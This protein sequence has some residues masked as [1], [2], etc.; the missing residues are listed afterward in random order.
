MAPETVQSATGHGITIATRFSPFARATAR[1][2]PG[3]PSRSASMLR[4]ST[5]TLSAI[6]RTSDSTSDVMIQFM[7]LVYPTSAQPSCTPVRLSAHCGRPSASKTAAP[8]PQLP[9]TNRPGFS[10]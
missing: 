10:E 4:R 9:S 5:P 6:V 1:T 3:S 7:L 8:I 2:A